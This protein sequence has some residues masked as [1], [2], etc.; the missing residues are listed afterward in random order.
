MVWWRRWRKIGDGRKVWGCKVGRRRN[1]L[2]RG[3]GV[4]GRFVWRRGDKR[5]R[6]GI[7]MGGGRNGSV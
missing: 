2:V 3:F 4:A 6:L 1:S 7:S 5:V